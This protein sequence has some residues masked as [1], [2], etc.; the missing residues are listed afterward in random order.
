MK[1]GREWRRGEREQQVTAQHTYTHTYIHKPAALG[2]RWQTES[3]PLGGANH[4]AH[5]YSLWIDCAKREAK[6]IPIC[7]KAIRKLP[8]SRLYLIGA[9]NCPRSPSHHF[10]IDFP[11]VIH[12]TECLDLKVEESYG[13]FRGD[14]NDNWPLFPRFSCNRSTAGSNSTHIL[15]V[16]SRRI[17]AWTPFQGPSKSVMDSD[18]GTLRDKKQSQRDC[19]SSL[20][21][22]ELID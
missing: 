5:A 6:R 19:G 18:R 4:Q 7:L 10:A 2:G 16:C 12:V 22:D 15:K 21:V 17:P 1:N 13:H 8:H 20:F 9:S 3:I 11:W 14:S